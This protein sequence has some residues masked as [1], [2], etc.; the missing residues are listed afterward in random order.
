MAPS[1]AAR[2]TSRRNTPVSPP[3]ILGPVASSS[4]PAGRRSTRSQNRDISV[5]SDEQSSLA[6]RRPEESKGERLPEPG[7][8][9]RTIRLILPQHVPSYTLLT[10]NLVL[11][12]VPEN[13]EVEYPEL[14]PSDAPDVAID[15]NDDEY[16][17]S[18]SAHSGIT[19]YTQ[20]ELSKLD[21]E[22]MANALPFLYQYSDSM[23]NLFSSGN[24]AQLE[25]LHRDL[26]EPTS[27]ASKKLNTLLEGFMLNRKHYGD[28][29]AIDLDIAVRALVGLRHND[30]IPDGNW[31]PDAV[32]YMANLARYTATSYSSHENSEDARVILTWMFNS[33]PAPFGTVFDAEAEVPGQHSSNLIV[34]STLELVLEIRTQY[35]FQELSQKQSHPAFDPDEI[36]RAIFYVDH[37]RLRGP[38]YMEEFSTLPSTFEAVFTKRI[39]A[40]RQHFSNNISN[41]VEFNGLR[42]AF[43]YTGF[44]V[45]LA[46]W[47]SLMTKQHQDVIAEHGGISQIQSQLQDEYERRHYREE[48][49]ISTRIQPRL[50]E[51]PGEAQ[52]NSEGAE[53]SEVAKATNDTDPASLPAPN[54]PSIGKASK[55][56]RRKSQ[57]RKS[58]DWRAKQQQTSHEL[59]AAS[60]ARKAAEAAENAQETL[61]PAMNAPAYDLQSGGDVDPILLS[62]PRTQRVPA[63]SQQ[64]LT[65]LAT[66]RTHA[67]QSNKENIDN[68]RKGK[69][70]FIDRQPGAERINFDSQD[71]AL[72]LRGNSSTKRKASETDGDDEEG[73]FEVDSRS[74]YPGPRGQNSTQPQRIAEDSRWSKAATNEHTSRGSPSKRARVEYTR[75]NMTN[76]E[77]DDDDDD[78]DEEEDDDNVAASSQLRREEA[79]RDQHRSASSIS[80]NRR[81]PLHERHNVLPS[82]SAPASRSSAAPPIGSQV[83]AVNREARLNTA[84]LLA[85]A[86]KPQ[87]RSRWTEVEVERLV[88]LIEDYGVSWAN[89]LK[90]DL[91]HPGR[92][93]L[94]ERD[95]VSLKDKARNMKMDF[96]KYV[97]L[98]TPVMLGC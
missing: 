47:A 10:P 70:A 24:A 38:D 5:A 17:D 40:I 29:T 41:P 4:Q 80:S 25:C 42:Q 81:L 86:K 62:P 52:R 95:Q 69:M 53:T 94:Q 65:V 79:N 46:R 20:F 61:P 57:Q 75:R 59:L 54:S 87:Q 68:S 7:E 72:A 13:A 78:D 85:G 43:P 14:N 8:Y 66:L 67:T 71:E 89:L 93:V 98:S 90:L 51:R 21:Q 39:K 64:A 49:A 96:L 50:A 56:T 45:R 9:L 27:R 82:S 58:L 33:F 2:S 91:N 3:K 18:S 73:D 11:D 12:T 76:N 83:M 60:K 97:F 28:D 31:R 55:T 19:S 44:L 30:E 77:D 92:P 26:Q 15:L 48:G 22:S 35:L 23:L 34:N 88:E 37:D 74:A 32:L 1:R 63:P 16:D 6:G 84:M 36:L